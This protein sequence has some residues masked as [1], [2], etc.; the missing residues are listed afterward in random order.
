MEFTRFF[1]HLAPPAAFWGNFFFFFNFHW[2]HRNCLFS[3]VLLK[4]HPRHRQNLHFPRVLPFFYR[5]NSLT[6]DCTHFCSC[7]LKHLFHAP[8]HLYLP[9]RQT[10]FII[11]MSVYFVFFS[12]FASNR[13]PFEQR[14]ENIQYFTESQRLLAR[15]NRHGMA[16][17]RIAKR[18]NSWLCSRLPNANHSPWHRP[19]WVSC[20]SYRHC[21]SVLANISH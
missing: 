12:P 6:I 13:R 20:Q 14:S 9:A 18:S 5:L 10:N 17:N 11:L 1:D 3:W 16:T 7:L 8:T 19:E 2:L 15:S 21:Q 4:S